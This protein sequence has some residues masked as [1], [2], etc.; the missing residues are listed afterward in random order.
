VKLYNGLTNQIEE[1]TPIE[2]GKVRMYSCGP[3]VYGDLHIGN[4]AAFIYADVLRRVLKA[5]SYSISHVMNV[6]DID[7][8][9]IAGSK[10]IFPNQPPEAALKSLTDKYRYVFMA[11]LATT[12]NQTEEIQFVSAVESIPDMVLLIQKIID[13]D[14]AYKTDDGIYFSISKYI[15]GGHR[16]G[17]LQKINLETAKSRIASDEYD[18]DNAGDF[19]LWKAAVPG[20]PSWDATFTVNDIKLTMPGRPG[21]HIECSAMSQLLGVPFDIHTGGIDLKFPHHENEIAQSCA[22]G[23]DKLANVFVHNNHILVDG[24]KMSKSVGN[25]ITLREIEER[26]FSPM[27]FRLLVLE[28]HYQSESNFS[29]EILESAQNR[30][31]KWLQ[32]MDL[33]WQIV[34]GDATESS[35]TEFR[36]QLTAS[37]GNNLDTPG[38]MALIDQTFNKVES[39]IIPRSYLRVIAEV[40]DHMLGITLMANRTDINDEQKVLLKRRSSARQA[41]DWKQSDELRDQLSQQ[42]IGVKDGQNGQTWFRLT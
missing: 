10:K 20:E 23:F 29:W 6:T 18:K 8:K 42:G 36:Q 41:S 15:S 24:R 13:Q 40:I 39:G 25:I 26:G 11:D 22:A 28:S 9:T 19:A 27:A 37:L 3:T 31:K 32:V 2:P 1:F 30:L 34:D 35:D 21:W 14:Y 16:Y 7:D 5:H 33:I 4:L 12:G 17:L 38:T